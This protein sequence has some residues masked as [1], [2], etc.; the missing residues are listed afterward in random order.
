MQGR[1][2]LDWADQVVSVATAP[3]ARQLTAFAGA[4]LDVRH[5]AS[6]LGAEEAPPVPLLGFRLLAS[7]DAAP[8]DLRWAEQVLGG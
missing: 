2:E 8:R 3:A 6:L 7:P 1:A 4:A 5:M